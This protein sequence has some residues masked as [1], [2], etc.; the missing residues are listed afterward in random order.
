[1]QYSAHTCGDEWWTW[2]YVCGGIIWFLGYCLCICSYFKLFFNF[3]RCKW[4]H[5][6]SVFRSM[7]VWLLFF[8]LSTFLPTTFPV[9]LPWPEIL[10]LKVCSVFWT[11][12]CVFSFICKYACVVVHIYLYIHWVAVE[13]ECSIKWQLNILQSNLFSVYFTLWYS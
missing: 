5:F 6:Q 1:M 4:W 7:C 13:Y 12:S 9:P 2:N 11:F 8:Q 10:L 3:S